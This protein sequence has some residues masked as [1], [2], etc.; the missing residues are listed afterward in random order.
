[1]PYTPRF[2]IAA[3]I[4]ADTLLGAS[5]WARGSHA[6]NGTIPAFDPNPIPVAT[7]TS[8]ATVG[9]SPLAA[10]LSAGNDPSTAFAENTSSP[11]MMATRP[12][13][14]IT[15]YQ[16]PARATAGRLRCSATTSSNEV[17]AI[18]SQ[19]SRKVPTLPATGTS[20]IAV[21]N[22]GSVV[23]TSR[24]SRPCCRQYPMP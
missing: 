17:S 1:M 3:D 19:H 8:P 11:T 21:T 9:D 22:S 5:G 12:R 15:A 2:T 16:R 20:I 4:S 13:W 24:L 14:V 23:C 7:K 6:C 18:N 10:S